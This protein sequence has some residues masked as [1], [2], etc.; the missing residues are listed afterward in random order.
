MFLIFHKITERE[1]LCVN[2]IVYI[3]ETIYLLLLFIYKNSIIRLH[4]S[5]FTMHL[6]HAMFILCKNTRE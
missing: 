3:W 5:R 6:P 4:V 1:N 2:Y